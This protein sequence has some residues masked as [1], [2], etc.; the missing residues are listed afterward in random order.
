MPGRRDHHG[1]DGSLWFAENAANAYARMTTSGRVTEFL[2]RLSLPSRPGD[3]YG[4]DGSLWLTEIFGGKIARIQT[5]GAV[6]EFQ[7]GITGDPSEITVGPDGNLAR[8]PSPGATP[9]AASLRRASCASSAVSVRRTTS[10]TRDLES[11]TSPITDGTR[12]ESDLG[13]PRGPLA[14]EWARR[15]DVRPSRAL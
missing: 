8:S 6:T 3:I 15:R 14:R 2:D 1:P 7:Q 10:L 5:D 11:R 4:P 9:L 13:R 12:D